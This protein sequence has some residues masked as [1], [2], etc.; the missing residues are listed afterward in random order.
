MDHIPTDADLLKQFSRGNTEA[1]GALAERYESS[2]LGVAR[3]L[4]GGGAKEDLAREAV[5]ECWMRVIRHAGRFRGDSQVRTWIYRILVNRCLEKR[6]AEGRASRTAASAFTHAS[7]E[8][9]HDP[10]K[11]ASSEELSDQVSHA[12]EMLPEPM[13]VVLIL[14]Y[15][16]GLTHSQSAAVLDIPLGTLKTRLHNALA[17]LRES[18]TLEK[19]T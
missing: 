9:L 15:H 8:P 18:L 19:A 1:L 11:V 2:L 10:E 5:Q 4:L 17:R 16:R 13:R 14:C 6:A 12:V 7:V 3:G